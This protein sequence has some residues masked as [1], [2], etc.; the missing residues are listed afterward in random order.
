MSGY[1]SDGHE[2]AVGGLVSTFVPGSFGCHEALHMS[3]VLAE[4]VDRYLVEHPAIA[5]N[6]EWL[7]KATAASDAL[8]GLYQ[9]VGGV[10]FRGASDG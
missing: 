5:G 4:M 10:H 6:E 2:N 7:A 3:F 8:H 9:A 1:V